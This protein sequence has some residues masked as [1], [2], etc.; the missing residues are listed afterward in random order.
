MGSKKGE[1]HRPG[2]W[3]QQNKG[4]KHG[5]HRSK[6]AIDQVNKGR[7]S[8]KAITKKNKH[9][10]KRMERRNQMQQLRAKKREESLTQKR[11]LGGIG[12]PPFLVA[13]IPL[14]TVENPLSALDQLKSCDSTVD[15]SYSEFG[16][17]HISLPRFKQRFCFFVPPCGDLYSCLDAAKVADT[18]M[19][20]Y[21]VD[22]GIDAIGEKIL[23][24]LFSQGLPSTVHVVQGITE[25]SSKRR[26]ETR[27]N[28]QKMVERKF[29][30]EKLLGLDCSQDAILLLRQIGSQKQRN[31]TYRDR[32]P[33][34]LAE[35][36]S[37]EPN[38]DK[39]S[40]GTL[41]VT[42]YVRSCPVNVN[43][44]IHISGW[45][46]YLLRQIDNPVDPHPLN[47]CIQHGSKRKD[48]DGQATG[49]NTD[50]KMEFVEVLGRTD[51]T[52]QQLLQSENI[53]DP[54][55]GEQTWPTEAEL[56]E[57]EDALQ[58]TKRIVKKVPKG[59]SEYQSAWIV[60]SDNE[61]DDSCDDYD[62][63]DE[64]S[65]VPSMDHNDLN[66]SSKS[67]SGEEDENEEY[68]T[69]TVN[70]MGDDAQYDE[71]MDTDEEQLA[72]KKFKEARI[73]AMFPDEIDTPIDIAAKVRFQKY[74]GLKSFRTSPWDPKE[75]M[76]SDYAR[77]FQF[78]NFERTRKRVMAESGGEAKVGCYVTLHVANVP[79]H[80]VDEHVP[81]TPL[82]IYGLLPHENKM[83]V[84]N[85]AIKRIPSNDDDDDNEPI[86][87]K[88]K[89]IFHV[90]CRRFSACP[91]F[92]QHTSGD[93]HKYERFMRDDVAVV[94]TVYAP[95]VFRPCTVLVFKEQLEET[96]K[97]IAV[98]SVLSV[99][100]DRIVVKR[101]VLS[102][103]PFKIN[104]KSAVVRYMFFN[105]E[106][107][108]W[109]K[110]VEL[111]TKY[112]RRGHIKEPLG[113]HGHMKCVFDGPLKSQDTV[114]MHL[115]KRIYP[116]WT[117][118][119][120]V[121]NPLPLCSASTARTD[122]GVTMMITA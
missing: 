64:I 116:K 60:D 18:L 15:V 9:D 33:H 44:L 2:V 19:F 16:F 104:R 74:R 114:L 24:M 103:H 53:P 13:I 121:P 107:I 115:Y 108:N 62:D 94:A 6:G 91:I 43:N 89:L 52:K 76:P 41:K 99:N 14:S 48:K 61:I 40:E 66:A 78:A 110:P 20:L 31:I 21:N 71:K 5:R 26:T 109:F 22:V 84:I 79:K 63:D 69:I 75:N 97:L 34:L 86:K 12:S 95:I 85:M 10:L 73:D 54:M 56:Q 4:H 25:I 32:R 102:G 117:F 47:A 45:G 106:D 119:P 92:S 42:G 120:C 65:S 11:G 49:S 77:I 96:H 51:P 37:F 3:K 87:S 111:T 35:T 81:S 7:V 30:K 72:L 17:C 105:R 29:P 57:A 122:G 118:D 100:P 90:G 67:N 82:V 39:T 23:S 112:G 98:G 70:E 36:F 83:S 50:C 55:E 27:R 46:D 93:K 113:T 1:P 80:L 38:S 28:I 88:E 59:T 68:D 58:M 101:I 8:V